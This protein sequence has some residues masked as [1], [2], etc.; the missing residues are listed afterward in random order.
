[1]QEEI[2]GYVYWTRSPGYWLALTF[3]RALKRLQSRLLPLGMLNYAEA[4]IN[5]NENLSLSSLENTYLLLR[6]LNDAYVLHRITHL[7]HAAYIHYR[8]WYEPVD[9]SQLRPLSSHLYDTR[10]W[11]DLQQGC[12][13]LQ[14]PRKELGVAEFEKALSR[15]KSVNDI[16]RR[17]LAF[18]FLG[19]RLTSA[20]I[21]TAC[22]QYSLGLQ[23]AQAISLQT[24]IG[25]L[26]RRLGFA[27]RCAGHLNEAEEQFVLAAKHEA[28]PQCEYWLALS[29]GELGD[30]R[31]ARGRRSKKEKERNFFFDQARA[32][33]RSR[34][35]AFDKYQARNVVPISR[36]IAQQMFQCYKDNALQAVVVRPNAVELL[37]ELE[38]AGP[39][40]A[41]DMVMEA[42]YATELKPE[43][44]MPFL[45][46]RD[47]FYHYLADFPMGQS[48]EDGFSAYFSA[49]SS[50]T[51]ENDYRPPYLDVRIA[52]QKRMGR[53][54]D[55]STIANILHDYLRLPNVMFLLFSLSQGKTAKGQGQLTVAV[56]DAGEGRFLGPPHLLWYGEDYLRPH[57]ASYQNK[58]TLAQESG[59]PKPIYEAIGD[60]IE[61]YSKLLQPA[62]QS[63]WNIFKKRQVKIFPRSLMNEVPF[64]ALEVDGTPLVEICDVSYGQT[65][66]LIL[67]VHEKQPPTAC[68]RLT[69]VLDEGIRPYAGLV[70]ILKS[71]FKDDLKV[72]PNPSLREVKEA[73]AGGTS[74]ELLF[75][76]H[77]SLDP[78]DPQKSWL[79]FDGE[80]ET[81]FSEVLTNL[82]LKDCTCVTMGACQ[83]GLGRSIVS[84]EYLGLPVAFQA[85]GA[86][87]VIG[88][89][90]EVNKLA[91][92]ILLTDYYQA[93]H[94][95][96][97]VVSAF[98]DAQRRLKRMSTKD[99]L[100]WVAIG[101]PESPKTYLDM[102]CM[103]YPE[104][105]SNP[106]FWAGFY[107]S[108]DA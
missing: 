75:A 101:L 23:E 80:H 16:Y 54:Y 4:Q 90:W 64:Q 93:R 106:Y 5:L 17:V 22:Q 1:M 52:L 14:K 59:N 48:P 44:K 73:V 7:L 31:M 21:E 20:N 78:D 96:A 91:T 29:H 50:L 63:Y 57:H 49:L 42:R 95:G 34:R 88:S 19:D 2:R 43:H 82:Q 62:L 99:I 76:C 77:G 89:L 15:L 39:R 74:Q 58:V 38:A 65:P 105:F 60:L 53:V 107:V 47:R 87:Y 81:N 13:E 61:F 41:A 28:E 6:D 69:I 71:S 97:N 72:L 30:L 3:S 67:G 68:T 32:A 94:S 26:H 108:G 103:N 8:Q 35:Q 102:I 46:A 85:A 92:A 100:D 27:L 56:F 24:E 51:P 33:Y 25:H 9:Y 104:G 70:Q 98:N 37:G 40:N 45:Q 86:R 18:R 11:G 84:A 36:S 55:S 12:P 10:C 66:G 79:K 83:S